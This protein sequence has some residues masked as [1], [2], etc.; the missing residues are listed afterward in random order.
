MILINF[1]HPFTPAQT[2]EI[3]RQ[4]GSPIGR[5]VHRPAHFDQ[6][7]PFGEQARVLVESAE[8]TPEEWQGSPLLLNLPAL[9]V[10]AGLVL[11]EVHG[12]CGYFPTVVRLR[13][14]AD[15]VPP[16]FEVA[17]LLHLQ[18]VRESA[19]EHRT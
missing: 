3:E 8:L 9:S 10:I 2:V 5:L 14:A 1:S 16:Q 18:R 15:V 13:P 12:L 7:K 11:A 4:A 19:R 6:T 17:E